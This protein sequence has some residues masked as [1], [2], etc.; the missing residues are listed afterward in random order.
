MNKL[1]FIYHT[2]NRHGQ[3]LLFTSFEKAFKQVRKMLRDEI[4]DRMIIENIKPITLNNNRYY[5]IYP[6]QDGAQDE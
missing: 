5:D 1:L 2:G 3:I 4:T 6:L